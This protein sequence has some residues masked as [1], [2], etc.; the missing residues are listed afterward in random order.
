MLLVPRVGEADRGELY[1]P[2]GTH[3]NSSV[4]LLSPS[5]RQTISGSSRL[6]NVL[7]DDRCEDRYGQLASRAR[8]TAASWDFTPSLLRIDWI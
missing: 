5:A 1:H 8:A 7:S 3:R 4:H 6:L 2:A